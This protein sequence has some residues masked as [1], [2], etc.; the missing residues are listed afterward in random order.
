MVLGSY[1]PWSRSLVPKVP[2]PK[3]PGQVMVPGQGPRTAS[4]STEAQTRILG[5][6]LTNL[7]TL[8]A[9]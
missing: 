5:A 8:V 7:T 3:V 1:G 2:S 9:H 6:D 4:L